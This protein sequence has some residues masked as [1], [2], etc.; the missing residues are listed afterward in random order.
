MIVDMSDEHFKLP[1]ILTE[2]VGTVEQIEKWAVGNTREK[3]DFL[4]NEY[5]RLTE[6]L[7]NSANAA[8]EHR[9]DLASEELS[10]AH[11]VW[12]T[13]RHL[14]KE[15]DRVP[16]LNS[17]FET[18]LE[19]DLSLQFVMAAARDARRP[20]DHKKFLD[21]L[22]DD[23][24][25]KFIELVEGTR[26]QT[27]VIDDYIKRIATA[28]DDDL[29]AQFYEPAFRHIREQT[30]GC[31]SV[32]FGQ[33][34]HTNVL[35]NNR[36]FAK[37]QPQATMEFDLPRRRIM[38]AEAMQSAQAAYNDYGALMNDPNFLALT[39]LNSGQPTAAT[40][41]SGNNS[42]VRDVLP[43]LPSQTGEGAVAQGRTFQPEFD[44]QLEALI[45][46]PA[47]YKFETGTGYEIRP[48]IQPDGQSVVFDFNYMYTTNIREPIRADEK[49]LG[50]VK[51]HF[52]DTDVQI[53][54]YE[55]R[56]VSRYRV[57]LKASRTSR[58]V[59]LLE[60]IPVAGAL[61]RPQPSEESSLQ[62]NIILAKAVIFPTLYDLMGLR[63]APA[64]ADL[65]VDDLKNQEFIYR[66]RMKWIKNE[67]YD[68]SSTQVDEFLRVPM[69]ERRADLYRDQKEIP[70]THPDFRTPL[71]NNRFDSQLQEGYGP[72]S[73]LTPTLS[74]PER[75]VPLLPAP[76]SGSRTN[77][78]PAVPEP[79]I[80]L[81][82]LQAPPEV[83]DTG[84]DLGTSWSP[85]K[86]VTHAKA[87]SRQTPW[88][89]P[90]V[91]P[92][93]DEPL[94]NWKKS[95]IQQMSFVA[96]SEHESNQTS[97]GFR[98]DELRSAVYETAEVPSTL[99]GNAFSPSI[100]SERLFGT[101][102]NDDFVSLSQEQSS[103]PESS[104]Q[105]NSTAAHLPITSHHPDVETQKPDPEHSRGS[106]LRRPVVPSRQERTESRRWSWNPLRKFFKK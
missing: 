47:I 37:V 54:N 102:S 74:S 88:P 40:H 13:I 59:P 84:V 46:D 22:I 4:G 35:T 1:P 45:P 18:L 41:D 24:E 76:A 15:S 49:H 55:L 10:K 20:L 103:E 104:L 81:P 33:I 66:N 7:R 3:R 9:F 95:G 85:P 31:N 28:L 25:E 79:P 89:P 44:S 78:P 52:I 53:G 26:A 106:E 30:Y 65:D 62:Q 32:S 101:A 93:S 86:K 16:K 5:N 100:S 61:F 99:D 87:S 39:K 105:P 19:T 6:F 97:G 68:Y 96:D 21:M 14:L 91:P 94:A 36:M 70:R 63:W 51:R 69:E 38:I 72:A 92:A 90:L 67:V 77:V 2:L 73:N 80:S 29:N 11:E 75:S 56:E 23:T 64:V 42:L 43:G 60:D 57:A 71:G 83:D 82:R 17:A 27:A 34:E 98:E 48:V 8:I 12:A 50:R 58:G